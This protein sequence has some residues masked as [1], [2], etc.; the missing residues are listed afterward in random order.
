MLTAEVMRQI[1]RLQ[2]RAR[3]AVQT[4]LGGEYHS[5]F[6]GTGLS[7]E[8]VREYQP[9]D[10]VRAIDWNV[11]ARVGAPF[12]KRFVEER[13]LTVILAVD[14]S[15]SHR[16]GTQRHP[17]REVAAEV[18]ALLAFS[19]VANNDRVGL[20]TF[21]DAVER[22]IPPSK[23]TKHALRVLRDI[24]YY[25]P[26]RPGTSLR[27][28]LDFLNQAL[29]RRAIV[30]FISDWLDTDYE[31][32]F[33]LAA[34]RHDLIA[35]HVHDRREQELPAVGLLA[36]EDAETG[37]PLVIDTSHPRTQATFRATAQA[38][39]EA[40]RVL[41]RSSNVDL[42]DVSTD[43]DHFDALVKFFR[44]REARRRHRG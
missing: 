12:I 39:Q 22:Y 13:E 40:L 23:G 2:L 5:V 17:K 27:A 7:F 24:L 33:R 6:K 16:F 4:L 19:A 9:G 36:I 38:R 1:R 8:E 35:V 3:R 30:F 29:T 18:A 44:L 42:I 25:V 43:G 28:G 34:R 14:V 31:S 20:L 10:D 41:T 21:S 37:R 26:Q 11:T 32:S 15:S